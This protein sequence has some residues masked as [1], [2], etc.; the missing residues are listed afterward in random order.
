MNKQQVYNLRSITLIGP[1]HSRFHTLGPGPLSEILLKNAR[2]QCQKPRVVSWTA[3]I[4][5]CVNISHIISGRNAAWP[6]PTRHWVNSSED[7]ALTA[8]TAPGFTPPLH[9]PDHGHPPPQPASQALTHYRLIPITSFFLAVTRTSPA[10][11]SA[12][13]KA[14]PDFVVFDYVTICH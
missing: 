7:G 4:L 8:H 2:V 6:C 5:L 1:A 14:S 12:H 9:P 10:H 11:P 3:C 13:P